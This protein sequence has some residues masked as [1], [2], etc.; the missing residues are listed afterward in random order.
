[1]FVMIR[2]QALSP[3]SSTVL[4]GVNANSAVSLFLGA[5]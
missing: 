5:K 2:P 1:M 3:A 4:S